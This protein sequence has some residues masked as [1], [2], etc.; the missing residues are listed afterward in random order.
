M[1]FVQGFVGSLSR[2]LFIY[3]RYD[4]IYIDTSI[5]I[6]RYIDHVLTPI[7]L[8][9]T[10]GTNGT[11][12]SKKNGKTKL[13]LFLHQFNDLGY[14]FAQEGS[15][16]GEHFKTRMIY[17]RPLSQGRGGRGTALKLLEKRD[18]FATNS[19]LSLSCIQTNRNL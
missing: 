19:S 3:I 4:N 5:A 2:E 17:V 9:P 6:Y 18:S 7:P 16:T 14:H 13:L 12:N 15:A 11:I 10:N 8:G 1:H